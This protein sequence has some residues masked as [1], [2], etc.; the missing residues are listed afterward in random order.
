[1]ASTVQQEATSNRTDVILDNLMTASTLLADVADGPVNVPVLKGAA[2]L[3]RDIIA[4][5]QVCCP[6][7]MARLL[8]DTATESPQQQ[9]RRSQARRGHLALHDDNNSRIPA[10]S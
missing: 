5:A 1:M 4:I 3:A 9:G 8:A 6:I 10:G 7:S 2:G